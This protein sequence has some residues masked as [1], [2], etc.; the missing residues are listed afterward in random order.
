MESGCAFG[1]DFDT[2]MHANHH[3]PKMSGKFEMII[4]PEDTDLKSQVF[5]YNAE[6]GM[7]KMNL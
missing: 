4:S 6:I 7:G 5:V 1:Q 3:S 2:E